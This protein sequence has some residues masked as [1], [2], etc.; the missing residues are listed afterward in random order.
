MVPFSFGSLGFWKTAAA[1]LGATLLCS[2]FSE[3][4]AQSIAIAAS[5]SVTPVVSREVLTP[6]AIVNW[7][8]R[9]SVPEIAR[10]ITVRILGDTVMGSGVIIERRGEAYTVLT[11]YHVVENSE[12]NDYAVLTADGRTH[13]GRWLRSTHF[14][15]LDLALVEFRSSQSYRVAEM[16]K[17]SSLLANNAVYASGF[18]NW[19]FEPGV[20]EN[21][22][23]WGLRA[24]RLTRGTVEML[25]RK[26]L[27][28]GYQ[29][30]YTNEIKTGMSGGPVLNQDGK[31]VGINGLRK[32]PLMGVDAFVFA[33]GTRPS[34]AEAEQMLPL[35]WAIPIASLDSENRSPEA[36]IERDSSES[37]SG[38]SPFE[39]ET[40][41]NPFGDLFELVF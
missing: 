2:S 10:Q 18:P 32:F 33:D 31:L 1:F 36:E 30:G 3:R 38:D 7:Q 41:D 15:D 16:E 8:S 26:P 14:Q 25:A 4:A 39:A 11:N 20:A 17:S 29:L 24:Y 21:T 9:V 23:D 28:S 19:H 6:Q 27:E 5:G 34:Q 37:R 35:S 40:E 12:G 13:S 22:R